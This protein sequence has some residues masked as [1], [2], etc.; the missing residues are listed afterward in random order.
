[1]PDHKLW[2]KPKDGDARGIL[3]EDGVVI[4]WPESEMEHGTRATSLG[5][6]GGWRAFYVHVEAAGV[7]RLSQY[8]LGDEHVPAVL[9][10][11]PRIEPPRYWNPPA[12][13]R[14]RRPQPVAADTVSA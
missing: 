3:C 11:L 5:L 10:A 8:E 14:C 9:A 12:T 4:V 13:T 2:W 6:S 1:M 7:L